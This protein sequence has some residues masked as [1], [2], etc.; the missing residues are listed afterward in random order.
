LENGRTNLQP[1]HLSIFSTAIDS[2]DKEERAK[3]R[4][5]QENMEEK[6]RVEKS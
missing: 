1:L 6:I 5:P 3:S 2:M 4:F